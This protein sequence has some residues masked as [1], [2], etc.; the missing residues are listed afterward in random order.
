M[1]VLGIDQRQSARDR[2]NWTAA[3]DF[4]DQIAALGWIVKDTSDGPVISKS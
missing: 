1:T 3:D 2:K 4:R